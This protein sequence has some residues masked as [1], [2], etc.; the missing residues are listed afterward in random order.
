MTS[1]KLILAAGVASL[2]GCQVEGGLSA[3]RRHTLGSSK[4][5]SSIAT[6]ASASQGQS[7]LAY[8]N[9]RLITL[10][11]LQQ[12]FI[13]VSGG[14]VL[15]EMV[16]DQMVQHRL[17]KAGL[18]LT[19]EHLHAEQRVMAVTLHAD[20]DVAARLLG[21]LRQRRGLG[22]HRFRNLL[23]RNAGLRLL[24]QD[25][26][27]VPDASVRQAHELRHGPRFEARLI[28]VESLSQASGLV[29]RAR[30]GESFIALARQ[31][32][33]DS[34]RVHGGLLPLISPVDST[35]PKAIRAVLG[36]LTPGHIS[37]PVSMENGFGILKLEREIDPQA[38]EFDDVKNELA[39]QVRR[40]Y[41]RALMEQLA[42]TLIREA[43]LI[44]VSRPLQESWMNQ[45]RSLLQ[46][47]Q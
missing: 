17:G 6:K 21:Q 30:S 40:R 2:V 8:L 45:K 46:D 31:N 18:K 12:P 38:I 1:I 3:A 22:E 47:H 15:A 5:A 10:K 19:D 35:F 28:M 43:D 33:T 20:R 42:R 23:R 36:R 13:E 25:Q 39:Q 41:E 14:Q 24:V 27:Q 11:D 9:G 4:P 7:P 16:L 32:S 26:V 44:V 34:S 37:D 29:R